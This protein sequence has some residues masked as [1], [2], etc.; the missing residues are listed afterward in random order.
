MIANIVGT[1]LSIPLMYLFMYTFDFGL[2]GIP[3]AQAFVSLII[4]AIV[5]TYSF[6]QPEV[7]SVLQPLNREVFEGWCEYLRISIPATVMM[8]AESWAIQGL[9]VMATILGVLELAS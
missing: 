3:F 5:L 7:K 2:S 4:F 1:I 8:V 9:T 6:C